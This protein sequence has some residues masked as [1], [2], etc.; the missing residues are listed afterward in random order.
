MDEAKLLGGNRVVSVTVCDFAFISVVCLLGEMC[1][2]I[3]GE[4]LGAYGCIWVHTMLLLC[5]C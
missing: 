1:G 3:M 2:C 4:G 5:V